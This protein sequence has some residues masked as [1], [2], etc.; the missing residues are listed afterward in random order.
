MDPK[1]RAVF[2]SELDRALIEFLFKTSTN[3]LRKMFGLLIPTQRSTCSFSKV[4][5]HLL[6]NDP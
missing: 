1:D 4:H 2:L 3:P 6:Q 5:G